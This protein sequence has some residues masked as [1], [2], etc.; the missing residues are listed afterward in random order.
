MMAKRT[1]L[2]GMLICATSVAAFG[3]PAA[4]APNVGGDIGLFTMS[5]ADNPR[6]GQFTMGMY[7]WYQPQIAGPFFLNQQDESRYFAQYGGNV[8]LGL[9]LTNWWSVFVSGGGQVTRSEGGWAAGYLNFCSALGT[10]HSCR[11]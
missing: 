3:Q 7:A 4:V 8:S 11:L 5:T 1:V 9:G 10:H 6:A 2:L